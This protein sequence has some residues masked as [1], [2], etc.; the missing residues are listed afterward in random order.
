MFGNQPGDAAETHALKP[1]A[2]GSGGCGRHA[3]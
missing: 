3:V 1:L 2:A